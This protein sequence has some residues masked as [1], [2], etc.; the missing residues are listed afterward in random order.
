MFG[1]HVSRSIAI[2]VAVDKLGKD[3]GGTHSEI[4]GNMDMVLVSRFFIA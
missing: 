2:S 4:R 1:S 3:C